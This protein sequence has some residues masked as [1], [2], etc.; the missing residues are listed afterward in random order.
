MSI[1][2][3]FESNLNVPVNTCFYNLLSHGAVHLMS[4]KQRIYIEK[5]NASFL[6]Y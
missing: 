6:V 2:V 5:R 3:L 1:F 4:N